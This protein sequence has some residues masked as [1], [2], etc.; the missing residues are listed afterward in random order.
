[1]NGNVSRLF[2]SRSPF[3]FPPPPPS[4]SEG[5]DFSIFYVV[6]KKGYCSTPARARAGGQ[7][8]G[9]APKEGGGWSK[10][11]GFFIS[12][13][14]AKVLISGKPSADEIVSCFE[15][16][17]LRMESRNAEGGSLEGGRER[18]N[19]WGLSLLNREG[20]EARSDEMTFS[21]FYA[22]RGRD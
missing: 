17:S 4:V 7:G 15:L 11:R 6:A 8:Q 1:M 18:K 3:S 14:S 2:T 20:V 12:V 5:A 13:R 22:K 9:L 19:E 10:P 21:F 16:P